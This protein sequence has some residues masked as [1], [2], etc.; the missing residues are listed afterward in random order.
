MKRHSLV[1][2]FRLTATLI[3]LATIA[4]T[5]VTW[6]LVAGLY[7]SAQYRS[8]YPANHAERQIPE[9]ESYIKKTGEKLLETEAQ[10]ELTEKLGNNIGYQVVDALGVQL[11]GN[12][13]DA[14]FTS[15]DE[16]ISRLNTSRPYRDKSTYLH[17]VPLTA[18][19][20]KLVGAVALVYS[21]KPTAADWR[22]SWIMVIVIA[23]LFSPVFYIVF[24]TWLFS[25]FFVKR[26][27]R[28]LKLLVEAAG[29]IKQKQLD[30]EINYHSENELGELCRAFS[31][32]QTELK[33][34]LSAQ[35][36]LEQERLELVATLAHDLKTPISIV[37]GY[38]QSLLDNHT[39]EAKRHRY[40]AVIEENAQKCTTLVSQMQ[41]VNELEHSADIRLITT[42]LADF[43]KRSIVTHELAAQEKGIT[44]KISGF[45]SLPAR[46]SLDTEKVGRIIDNLMANS[47]RYTPSGGTIKIA[48]FA[49]SGRIEY[50]I[51]DSGPGFGKLDLKAA[52]KPFYR[53]DAAR[54]TAEAHSGLGLY[55]V[56]TLVE[57]L[58]G[59]VTLG[60]QETGGACVRFW[61]EIH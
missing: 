10:A 61:H 60:N 23:G 53:G 57:K 55:I 40:L 1:K 38:S 17:V 7:L 49:R 30:F 41:F 35:W 21:L 8:I 46:C 28:P 2:D 54:S 4:A 51:C 48:L 19:N 26:I 25:R 50:E 11:Y 12:L 58:G 43:L 16:L 32:M 37:L 15:E 27:N 20:G 45:E 42:D 34:S 39:D 36:K 44:L 18:G 9:L 24:F 14:L 29:K 5:I 6:L 22:G 31:E 56:A 47:L 52:L 3:A 13:S 33:E 59:A